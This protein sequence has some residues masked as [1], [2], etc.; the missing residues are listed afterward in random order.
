MPRTTVNFD[1]ILNEDPLNLF[2][3]AYRLEM[4]LAKASGFD[5]EGDLMSK[6][7]VEIR[8][9]ATFIVSKRR[10]EESVA[11]VGSVQL[12]LRPAEGDLLYFPLTKSFFEIRRVEHKDPFFQV[13]KFNVFKLDCELAQFSSERV[14]TK[15]E[16]INDL[17]QNTAHD[18]QSHQLLLET[19]EA[20]L[21]EH[22]T[23]SRIILED[24][25]MVDIDAS[26]Q[27]EYFRDNI[28]ILDFSE[29]N[30]FG[31]LQ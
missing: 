26:A 15:I 29:R 23:E 5:G 13:G 28:G 4:Y 9:T 14:D 3:Q 6:F 24:F 10:W 21:L 2:D 31:E 1:N 20:L 30:P 25:K 22:F 19:G 8:D 17:A 18:I 16:E 12:E 7:G 27:N 11:R